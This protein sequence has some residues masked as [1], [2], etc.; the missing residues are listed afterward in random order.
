VF[1]LSSRE[2]SFPLVVL[3]AMALGRPVVAFDVGSVADQLGEAGVVIAPGD[4]EAMADAVV[5]LLDDRV[6]ARELGEAAAARAREIHD[7]GGF[8]QGVRRI[9]ASLSP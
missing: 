6:K 2:D 4:T 8:R 1:T 5:A 3:E 7:V 9:V